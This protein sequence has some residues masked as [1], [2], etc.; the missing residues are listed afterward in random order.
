MDN[1]KLA[2]LLYPEA[3][4]V[5]FWFERYK[6]R[7]LPKGAEVTRFAPSPTGFLH[8]GGLFGALVDA[9]IARQ[10]NGVCYLRIEDTDQ[11]RKVKNGVEGI[12][13][14]FRMFDVGFNEGKL[15]MD[16]EVG[17]Y[18]P[19][20]QSNRR[21][22][23]KSFAKEM[24]LRGKAYPCFCSEDEL[25]NLREQQM[26]KKLN[27]GYY[28]QYAKCRNLSYEQIADNIKAGK[29][30][31]LR[32]RC[33]YTQDDKIETNDLV[34]GNRIIPCNYNDV[35]IMKSNNLPP[36]NFAHVVDDTLMHTTLV[37]RSDEWFPSFTEHLQ[38][39]EALGLTPPK[40]A[41]TSAMQKI[42]EQTNERRKISKRKDPEANVVFFVEQGYP[43][44]AI[45]DY[46]MIIANSNF[47]DWRAQNPKANISEFK[48]DISKLNTS[49]AL[50]D[51]V[52][53]SDVSKN[54]ISNMTGQQVFDA[55]SSWASRFDTDF[56]KLLSQNKDYYTQ[57]LNIDRDIPK[58]RKDISHWAE[59]RTMYEYMFDDVFDNLNFAFPEKFSNAQIIEV[60]QNYPNYFNPTDDQTQ[61]FGRIKDLAEYIGWAREVKLF[62][63]QPDLYPGHCGDVSTILRVAL[64]GRTMTPNLYNICMLLGKDRI[65]Y[66]LNKVLNKLKT[67]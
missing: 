48:F 49:G 39:F 62:K 52:K 28:G 19:Y 64:T 46:L 27:P 60:L 14:S 23:Y 43:V 10:T 35:V 50:F 7:N 30:W 63:Q 36:Y 18:G 25:N 32:F 24:V 21:E 26:A 53:L 55:V 8:I 65:E 38:L 58:P 16:N 61:W 45:F 67:A 44:E 2:D 13:D 37:V 31:V 22:I 3:K 40:Y 12:I 17:D 29:P 34:R 41:H 66:R 1:K 47:E 42:D 9:T 6:P 33:P 4:S 59:V 15:S 11:K 56:Y 20:V 57:I 51:M 54:T 5:D